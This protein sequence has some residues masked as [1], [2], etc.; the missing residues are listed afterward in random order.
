MTWLAALHS[1]RRMLL[2][3]IPPLRHLLSAALVAALSLVSGAVSAAEVNDLYMAEVPAPASAGAP[4]D[5]ALAAALQQVLVKV[6]GQTDVAGSATVREALSA[7]GAL[8]LSYGTVS[9]PDP[10]GGPPLSLLS[11]RF[12]ARAVDRLLRD[13]GL[14][15]WGRARPG[16]LA[17]VALQA[18]GG[19]V[20]LGSDE[21]PDASRVLRNAAGR[22]GIPLDVPLLDLED[23]A[24]VGEADVWQANLPALREASER[25]GAEAVLVGRAEQVLPT[26]WEIGWTLMYDGDVQQWRTRADVLELALEDGVGEAAD[27]MARR[28]VSLLQSGGVAD[29]SG[30]VIQVT[31]VHG[32][33]DYARTLD[34]LGALEPV[35]SVALMRAEGTTLKLHVRGRTGDEAMRRVIGLGNTLA[36]AGEAD[37]DTFRL[38]P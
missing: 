9:R 23:R 30:L 16:V 29:G 18:E 6:S 17:W 36:P 15:V 14:P 31:G 13:A 26:L 11:A 3:H 22:R 37:A 5:E 1:V 21:A 7:P 4:T 28:Y 20:L 10:D 8:V 32:V 33:R 38:R 19:R 2:R 27:A 24:R 25:Y 12:D 35:E 34:Y